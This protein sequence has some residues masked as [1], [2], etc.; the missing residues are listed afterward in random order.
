MKGA[1]DEAAPSPRVPLPF[2]TDYDSLEQMV[3]TA[4]ATEHFRR[5]QKRGGARRT[6]LSLSLFLFC[7]NARA[8]CKNKTVL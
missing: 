6:I 8:G 4:T 2:I 3:A 7:G 5:H 1:Q